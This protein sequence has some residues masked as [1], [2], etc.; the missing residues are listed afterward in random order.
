MIKCGRD[1]S[2]NPQH[3]SQMHWDRRHYANGPGDSVLVITM[4]DGTVHRVRHEPAYMMDHVDAY[5]VEQAILAAMAAPQALGLTDATRQAIAAGNAPYED[6]GICPT[7]EGRGHVPT[8]RGE[9]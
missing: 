7:C 2:V 5:K 6:Q 1:L 4:A 9:R 8:G 3:V